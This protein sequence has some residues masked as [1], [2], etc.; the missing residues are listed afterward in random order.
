MVLPL[1]DL[2]ALDS[3]DVSLP[4]DEFE[5]AS[6]FLNLLGGLTAQTSWIKLYLGFQVMLD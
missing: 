5:V 4:E 3:E 2:D 1:D 6:A